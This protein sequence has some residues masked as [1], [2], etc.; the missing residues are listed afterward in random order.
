MPFTP[1]HPAAILPLPRLLQKWA[2]PSALVIGSIAPDFI[3]FLPVTLSRGGSHSL[4][5]LLRFSLPLGWIVYLV[6]HLFL[7]HPIL[8]LL[9]AAI[10]RRL[11][12][13]TRT[14]R[15]PSVSWLAVTAC[16]LLGA[17]THLAWD[18][19]THE[20]APGVTALPFLRTDLFAL[21]NYHV[22]AYRVLQ[23]FSSAL[24]LL[25]LG[26]WSLR[27]FRQSVPGPDT[28]TPLSA[29][30]HMAAYTCLL[31]IP[32]LGGLSSAL[33]HLSLPLTPRGVE[34]AVG[35]GVVT[36]FSVFGIV[37]LGF[38]FWWHRRGSKSE[39]AP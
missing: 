8:D 12:S 25:I 26:W 21:G 3:Y 22:Y 23:H 15:L 4:A 33:A 9:P 5:G 27:W 34:I 13:A 2:V 14:M 36:V 17:A 18:A 38:A 24:G 7:K 32:A 10:S 28:P 19:F 11:D 35:N 16:L 31:G 30:E 6:Y 29:S 37:L 1:A 20:G 39:K